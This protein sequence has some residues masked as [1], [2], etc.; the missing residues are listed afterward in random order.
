L[1]I[2]LPP[3]GAALLAKHEVKVLDRRPRHY[4]LWFGNSPAGAELNAMVASWRDPKNDSPFEDRD[5]AMN[6]VGIAG[7][8]RSE[9]LCFPSSWGQYIVL[10]S[11]NNR[12]KI[13]EGQCYK[14]LGLSCLARTRDG[15]LILSARSKNVSHYAQMPHVS[16][17]G[18]VDRQRAQMSQSAVPQ[19]F[20]EIEE[21]LGVFPT[22][23]LYL[24]QLGVCEHSPADSALWD[25]LY[26]AELKLPSD[27]V[28]KRAENAKDGWEGKMS[29]HSPEE[30]RRMLENQKFH[31]AGAAALFL[32]L[33]S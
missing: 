24:R 7:L 26:F 10:S 12:Q 19:A 13:P 29:A 25:I 27:E 18:Y 8:D 20:T 11:E 1:P 23:V 22:E 30:V 28:L 3:Q 17:A 5:M 14:T 31:P 4:G 21:E 2:E 32:A 16:A 9:I 15:K 33:N 6:R